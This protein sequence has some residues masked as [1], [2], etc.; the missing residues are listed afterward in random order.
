M[1][2]RKCTGKMKFEEVENLQKLSREALLKIGQKLNIEVLDLRNR[3]CDRE[4]CS[5]RINEKNAYRDAS[6]ISVSESLAIA[7]YFAN[8]MNN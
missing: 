7:D 1:A 6:H 2:E 4:Y 8:Y 3:Y 5:T